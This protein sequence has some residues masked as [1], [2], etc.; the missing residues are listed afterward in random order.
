MKTE[1]D[2]HYHRA[3]GLLASIENDC[4]A[5]A[6]L[7]HSYG[8]SRHFGP[9]EQRQFLKLLQHGRRLLAN[10]EIL[11]RGKQSRRS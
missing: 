5:M 9:E 4:E 7:L 1:R 10:L 11:R 3:S 6:R 2:V 8:S